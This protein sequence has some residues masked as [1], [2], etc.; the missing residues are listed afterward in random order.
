MLE[1]AGGPWKQSRCFKAQASLE[2][3]LRHHGGTEAPAEALPE[4]SQRSSAPYACFEQSAVLLW[5]RRTPGTTAPGGGAGPWFHVAS[6]CGP[7]CFGGPLASFVSLGIVAMRG[8][9]EG[10][11]E[12]TAPGKSLQACLQAIP[13]TLQHSGSSVQRARGAGLR[14]QARP[15]SSVQLRGKLRVVSMCSTRKVQPP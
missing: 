7:T 11:V 13:Q 5:F 14:V 9:T 4:A 2:N 3:R 1:T 12:V 8:Q 6:I 15:F 10:I